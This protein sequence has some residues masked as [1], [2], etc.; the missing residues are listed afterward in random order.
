MNDAMKKI[1]GLL[2]AWGDSLSIAKLSEICDIDRADI[3]TIIADLN[4]FYQNNNSAMKII[5][6]NESV[7]LIARDECYD[8]IVKLF[9]TLPDKA[10]SK[11]IVEV[12]SIIAYN[13][14]VSKAQIEHIRGVS[15]ERA[16]A[17][18]VADGF[19][20]GYY[21]RELNARSKLY[22]TTEL[23]LKKFGL[24][25]LSDLPKIEQKKEFKHLQSSIEDI[26]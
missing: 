9:E 12:L 4:D 2:F 11:S 25:S 13:Q 24:K 22:K 15:C 18:L 23:F 17:K 19:I 20:K 1:E 5:Y 16:I 3:K 14:D 8:D 6:I 10:M 7:Q 21:N 26:L